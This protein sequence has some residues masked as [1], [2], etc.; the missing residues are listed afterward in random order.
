LKPS[1][2][3]LETCRDTEEIHRNISHHMDSQNLIGN[4]VWHSRGG[5]GFTELWNREREERESCSPERRTGTSTGGRRWGKIAVSE[6]DRWRSD[7]TAWEGRELESGEE[8]ESL[9]L[10]FGLEAI[11]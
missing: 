7:W 6:R 1:Q 11:F 4:W 8:T 2:R 10:G 5:I 9:W 3:E